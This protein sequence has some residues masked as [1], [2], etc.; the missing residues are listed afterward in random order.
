M[1]RL[2]GLLIAI[3]ART[4]LLEADHALFRP[5]LSLALAHLIHARNANPLL[6]AP[7]LH[8]AAHV[9][10]LARADS[11]LTYLERAS[12]LAPGNPHLWYLCGLRELALLQPV[13]ACSDWRHSLELSNAHLSDVLKVS[14]P[15]FPPPIIRTQILAE[16][17]N[18]LLFAAIYLFPAQEQARGAAPLS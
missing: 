12:R 17:P 3:Q 1:T 10:D 16:K 8:L 6:A 15:F 5:Q 14:T 11:P 9:R 18:R 13:R 4:Q 7:H 2:P